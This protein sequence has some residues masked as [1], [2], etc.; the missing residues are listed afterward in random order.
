MDGC[1]MDFYG[2]TDSYLPLIKIQMT[3]SYWDPWPTE[4]LLGY[5]GETFEQTGRLKPV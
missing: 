5:I 3:V 1:H 2:I 4:R